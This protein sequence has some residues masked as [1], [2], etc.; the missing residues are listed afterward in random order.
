MALSIVV[1]S[2]LLFVALVAAIVSLPRWCVRS[3]LRHRVWRLRDD[4]F[5]AALRGELPIGH[6]AVR[7]TLSRMDTVISNCHRFSLL[8]LGIF[9]QLLKRSP[10]SIRRS[11]DGRPPLPAKLYD[12]LTT[13]QRQLIKS[14][15]QRLLMSMVALVV[16]GTWFGFFRASWAVLAVRPEH[17]TPEAPEAANGWFGGAE[18]AVA[19]TRMGQA[20]RRALRESIAETEF[21]V[22]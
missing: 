8:R 17:R 21:A 13:E 15:E 18:E 1:V 7:A 6:P 9:S 20:A 10:D 16:L 12:H 4:M 14:Y 22:A 5:D 19:G 11:I 2:T 3:L